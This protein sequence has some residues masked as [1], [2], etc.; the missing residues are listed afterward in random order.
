MESVFS[1]DPMN[2]KTNKGHKTYWV[3]PKIEIKVT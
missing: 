2:I 3:L 1:R